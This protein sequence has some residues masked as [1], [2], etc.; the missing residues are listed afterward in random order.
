MTAEELKRYSF[1]QEE[2]DN[3]YG[4]NKNVCNFN[5]LSCKMSDNLVKYH[6]GHWDIP[7][8]LRRNTQTTSILEE[9]I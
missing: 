7:I 8:L 5:N 2:T 6:Y 1:G 4:N 9:D 3:Y